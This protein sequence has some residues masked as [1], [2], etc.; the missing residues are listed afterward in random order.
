MWV[1][2]FTAAV[3]RSL[4][5]NRPSKK[6]DGSISEQKK[7]S[8]AIESYQADTPSRAKYVQETQKRTKC[9]E[10]VKKRDNTRQGLFPSSSSKNIWLLSLASY[11]HGSH[12]PNGRDKKG[13][14][15]WLSFLSFSLYLSRENQQQVFYEEKERSLDRGR[16]R[17]RPK[18][19]F[20]LWGKS[21][22]HYYV[23]LERAFYVNSDHTN[24]KRKQGRILCLPLW[25]SK[26]GTNAR[27]LY[28]ESF[29]RKKNTANNSQAFLCPRID[30]SAFTWYL[31]LHCD[32]LWSRFHLSRGPFVA[33]AALVW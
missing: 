22:W 32:P 9:T 17:R 19:V 33:L 27:K 31:I 30:R 4:I 29:R 24:H 15:L 14:F 7:K 18:K 5:V 1:K 25:H 12:I 11:T 13:T 20:P 21:K 8:S 28:F 6:N 3:R 23:L 16:R 26:T 2:L 10:K